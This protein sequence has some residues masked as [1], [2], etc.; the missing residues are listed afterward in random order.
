MDCKAPFISG[1][2]NVRLS[3][4]SSFLCATMI[5]GCICSKTANA[6]NMAIVD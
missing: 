6:S 1:M 2:S 5:I 4:T 3:D